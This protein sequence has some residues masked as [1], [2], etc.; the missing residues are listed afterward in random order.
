MTAAS[1]KE[2]V[3]ILAIFVLFDYHLYCL[4]I[5]SE[6]LMVEHLRLSS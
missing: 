2:A 6:I 5:V 1:F 4:T 3:F